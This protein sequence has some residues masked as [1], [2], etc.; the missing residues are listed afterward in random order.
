TA[1]TFKNQATVNIDHSNTQKNT[2][3]NH[4]AKEIY[5]SV[6]FQKHFSQANSLNSSHYFLLHKKKPLKQIKN[7]PV[8]T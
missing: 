8:N 6:I 5:T 4:N 2:R 1:L 3:L 7:F